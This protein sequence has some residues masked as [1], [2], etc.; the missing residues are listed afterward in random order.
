MKRVV[1]YCRSAWEPQGGSSAVPSQAGAI[2]RYAKRRGLTLDL[3]YTDGGVSGATL[4]RPALQRLI[5]DCRAGKIGVVI[6]KDTARLSRDSSQLFTLL[7]IFEQ[8]GV[9]VEYSTQQG[10]KSLELLL[11]TL[12][13]LQDAT[14]RSKQ[15]Q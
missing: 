12:A 1:A 10:D 5:A 11:S 14:L 7:R 6:T 9:R 13:A 2:H 15:A 8:A 3:I 4:D